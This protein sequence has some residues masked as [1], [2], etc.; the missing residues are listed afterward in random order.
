MIA[1]IYF[2][3]RAAAEASV[4]LNGEKIGE[5]FITVDVD[6]KEK[7]AN[8]K[9]QNTVVVGNLKYGKSQRKILI[10]VQANCNF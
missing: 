7:A 2:D 8:V 3:T 6:S 5:N 1:F 9:P 10:Q 4:A